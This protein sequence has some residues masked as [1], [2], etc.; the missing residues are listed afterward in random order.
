MKKY[1]SNGYAI[2]L[3]K[4]S[5]LF[6]LFYFG[7]LAIIG[8]STK[9]NSYS[10]FVANYLD[11]VTPLRSVILHGAGRLLQWSGHQIAWIDDRTIGFPGGESIRMVYSCVG[12]G[13]LSFWAAFVLA[14]TGSG[15]KKAAWIMGGTLALCGINILRVYL[16]VIAINKGQKPPL[17]LDHHTWFNIAAYLLIFLMIGL[18]HRSSVGADKKLANEN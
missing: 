4:F 12:Y 11:Y 7:T 8:L 6:S 15:G 14:N 16:M 1:L 9:E 2:Y 5:G 18:Y 3:L 17:G 13:V 10:P